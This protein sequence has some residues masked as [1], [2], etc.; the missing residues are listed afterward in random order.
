MPQSYL[1]RRQL[2]VP[3][4]VR[5]VLSLLVHDPDGTYA[6]CTVGCGGHAVAV[7]GK[8]SHQ[9]RLIGLD[10][11]RES[12]LVANEKL[13]AF[14][15][16]VFL[17]N[18]DFRRLPEVLREL[19]VKFLSGAFFDLGISS[20]Q[21]ASN[22]GF[23]FQEEAPLDMRFDSSAGV[24]AADILNTYDEKR[25]A[26]ILKVYGDV[27]NAN[28]LAR[29]IA[30][31]R[32]KRSLSSTSHLVSAVSGVL[33]QRNLH[34]S[35][36][37]VFQAVRIAVND[38]LEAI[39][40]GLRLACASLCPGSRICVIAYHSGEDRIVKQ[41][42]REEVAFADGTRSRLELLTRKAVRPSKQEVATNPRSRSARLRAARR[43]EN[44]QIP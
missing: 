13:K 41:L 14:G 25:L 34:A 32:K 3:A 31:H 24:T 15:E 23:S 6:D 27:R 21:L 7:L 22:R 39:R 4:M 1:G 18:K 33:P 8:L 36:A 28:R 5:E 38:E 11:D 43:S 37:R 30:T 17:F 2:H 44:E 26:E 19:S 9:G 29:A 40:E 42:L 10:R 16:R 12:L 20:H 35:L